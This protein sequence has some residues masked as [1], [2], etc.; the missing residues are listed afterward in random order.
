MAE[1]ALR[2]TPPFGEFAANVG[3]N[4]FATLFFTAQCDTDSQLS[5]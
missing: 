2:V 1:A 4:G 5:A 3:V